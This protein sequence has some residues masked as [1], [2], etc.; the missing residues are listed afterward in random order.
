MLGGTPS[1][2]PRFYGIAFPVVSEW[3]LKLGGYASTRERSQYRYRAEEA[4][5]LEELAF[6]FVERGD[7]T[8]TFVGID[9]D[10]DLS[11]ERTHLRFGETFTIGSREGHSDFGLVLPHL[12]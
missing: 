11:H 5:T 8:R 3:C 7:G 9:P 2:C 4:G 12:F 10:L 1:S 6:G